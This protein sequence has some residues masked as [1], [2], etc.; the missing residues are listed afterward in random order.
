VKVV[1]SWMLFGVIVAGLSGETSSSWAQ[2][3]SEPTPADTAQPGT[4]PLMRD[5]TLS[6][7]TGTESSA[8]DAA[9][10]PPTGVEPSTGGG[11]ISAIAIDVPDKP[12]SRDVSEENRRIARELFLEG[13]RLFRIPLFAKAAEKY[14][15]ALGKWKHPAVYLNL[16]I[17]QLNAGQEVEAR[18]SLEHALEHGEEPLGADNFRGAQ[19]QLKQVT[20]Q[21]GRIRVSCRTQG[22]QVTLDGVLLFIGPGSYEGWVK[23]KDHEITAKKPE[24]LSEARRVTVS[25]G[26]LQRLEL[27]LITLSEATDASRRWAAWKPKLIT[28]VGGAIVAVGGVLHTVAFRN[29]RAYDDEVARLDCGNP[30]VDRSSGCA[31]DDPELR[32]FDGLLRRA[33]RQ[34]QI[35]V[36][37]YIVGVPLVAAGVVLLYM[38]RPHLKELRN[39]NSSSNPISVVPLVSSDSLGI[40]L[41]VSK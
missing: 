7:S 34:Q 11:A 1:C 6:P 26:Q 15:A 13:N 16:A 38:N 37:S 20:H 32:K 28:A 21:L 24:Y 40:V 35:A 31:Q 9:Q 5:A 19:L 27:R 23:A 22:A 33:R 17:A 18:D 39:A 4:E 30:I 2:P 10:P 36:G 29:F 8:R 14:V 41:S 3:V 25:S 12:W